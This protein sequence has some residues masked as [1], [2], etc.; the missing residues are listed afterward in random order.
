MEKTNWYAVFTASRAEK[1][2]KERLEQAEIE[3]YLP[4]RKVEFERNGQVRRLEIPVITGCIFVRVS[5]MNLPS[6]LSIG[7]VIALLKEKQ[8]PVVISDEQLDS[9]RILNE[10]AGSLEVVSGK[11]LV[12]S[13]VRVIQGELTGVQG[14]VG[15][16]GWW[17]SGCGSYSVFDRRL[18]GC[19]IR[20]CKGV[21]N[22]QI[23]YFFRKSVFI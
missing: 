3:N 10:N 17:T 13:G 1:R 15:R 6:V 11:A 8:G 12:G 4:V 22:I 9:L 5:E 20:L 18:C 7:G 2:V 16:G 19:F 14:G 21:V 23:Y